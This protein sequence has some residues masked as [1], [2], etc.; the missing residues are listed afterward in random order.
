MRG[1]ILTVVESDRSVVDILEV[2]NAGSYAD[3]L[4]YKVIISYVACKDP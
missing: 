4:L 1:V 2:S 3:A